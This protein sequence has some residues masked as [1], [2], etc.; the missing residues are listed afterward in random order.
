QAHLGQQRD[1]G[2]RER[3]LKSIGPLGGFPGREC[4]RLDLVERRG[5]SGARLS[6][7]PPREGAAGDLRRTPQLGFLQSRNRDAPDVIAMELLRQLARIRGNRSAPCSTYS[8]GENRN[9][10]FPELRQCIGALPFPALAIGY[11]ENRPMSSL[12]FVLE[13]FRRGGEG[14]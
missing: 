2:E 1:D 13:H 9:L 3:P 10:L 11:D 14:A 4:D 5:Q 6:V 12:A 8:D 7:V